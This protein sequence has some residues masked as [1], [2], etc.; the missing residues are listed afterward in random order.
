MVFCPWL[1]LPRNAV[2]EN[3]PDPVWL[4]MPCSAQECFLAESLP[5]RLWN[6]TKR[7]LI[8]HVHPTVFFAVSLARRAPLTKVAGS[9]MTYVSGILELTL[10]WRIFWPTRRLKPNSGLTLC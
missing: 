4:P 3:S 9:I 5:Q 8:S 2:L 10:F 6:K 7:R 1:T